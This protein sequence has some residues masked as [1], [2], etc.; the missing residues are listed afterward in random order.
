MAIIECPNCGRTVSDTAPN[1]PDCGVPIATTQQETV[2]A[3]AHRPP[4]ISLHP[5]KPEPAK[6]AA[7]PASTGTRVESASGWAIAAVVVGVAGIALVMVA[8]AADV[9][10]P[11][12]LGLVLGV[13]GAAFALVARTVAS[14]GAD[15]RPGAGHQERLEAGRTAARRRAPITALGWLVC[16]AAVLVNVLWLMAT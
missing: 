12:F 6:P 10:W 16:G 7:P 13:A 5:S 8:A 9:S 14:R 1:C 15:V 2:D 3:P 4:P 11:A